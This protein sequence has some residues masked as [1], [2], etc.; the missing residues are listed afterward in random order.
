MSVTSGGRTLEL[1]EGARR[2][3]AWTFARVRG[4]LGRRVLEIGCGTGTITEFLRDRELVVGVDVV[5]Y[6]VA[7]AQALFRNQPNVL[8]RL[9][10]MRASIEELRVHRFDS[11][12]SVNVMEHIEDDLAVFRAANALL[13]S[14]GRISLL[15]PAHGW[16][17]SPFDRSIGHYRRYSKQDLR[18][19]LEAAGFQV[20]RV[21]RS[22]PLGAVGWL[23]NNVALR[24]GQLRG[25]QLY[26]RFVPLLA[27]IDRIAEPPVG[28]S[29]LAVA[30]KR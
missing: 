5:D 7:S 18:Q 9:Q 3:N 30:R 15:V 16:L 8:I 11:V 28:L 1:L 27:T 22:N 13:G 29:L 24:R 19:K 26:D 25:V 2:Y 20:E 12:L 23:V 6:Y 21:R 14:G 10:D 4:A 17:M